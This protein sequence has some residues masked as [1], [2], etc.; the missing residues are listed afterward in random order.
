LT[1][2]TIPW[3]V[4]P[5]PLPGEQDLSRTCPAGALCVRILDTSSTP[6]W[7]RN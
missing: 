3:A 4:L 5:I 7:A 2:V 6:C 1:V